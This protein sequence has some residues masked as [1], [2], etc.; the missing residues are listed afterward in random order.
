MFE[1][2]LA[3]LSLAL[4]AAEISYMVIGGQAVLV[5]GE[6]RLTQDVD[7]VLGL[8]PDQVEEVVRLAEQLNL[9]PDEGALS[10]ARDSYVYPC[11]DRETGTRVD[12]VFSS[13]EYERLAIN[14]AQTRVFGDVGVRFVSI[15]DLLILRVVAG[16]AIDPVDVRNV[17][18]KTRM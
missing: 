4:D 15:E 14:R 6:P 5:Y 7:I 3:R 9:T 16:L 10:L 17:L 18:L 8:S 12:L 11:V 1:Q 13:S 2:L